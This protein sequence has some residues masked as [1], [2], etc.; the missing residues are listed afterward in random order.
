[1]NIKK[2][3]YLRVCEILEDQLQDVLYKTRNNRYT[4]NTIVKEQSILKR[5]RGELQ[6]L[7]NF[8]KK[9]GGGK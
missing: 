9:K 2:E 5:S 4:I 8:I 3:V 6:K 7:I 1:M